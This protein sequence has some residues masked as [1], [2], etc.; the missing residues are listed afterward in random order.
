[1]PWDSYLSTKRKIRFNIY[2]QHF[3]LKDILNSA[4]IC[5]GMEVFEANRGA[6]HARGK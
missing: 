4:N 6:R 3:L 1:L 2:N 5:P